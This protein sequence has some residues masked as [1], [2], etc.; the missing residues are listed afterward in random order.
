MD[1]KPNNRFL[2]FLVLWMKKVQEILSRTW[3][4]QRTISWRLTSSRI[5]SITLNQRKRAGKQLSTFRKNLIAFLKKWL[6]RN[7]TR[8][9]DCWDIIQLMPLHH[10]CQ[11]CVH[12]W[13]NY[14]TVTSQTCFVSSGVHFYFLG[15]WW[16]K[17]LAACH[18]GGGC[19]TS[20]HSS[21]RVSPE[22][23]EKIYNEYE[24]MHDAGVIR[25]NWI[26]YSSL[27]ILMKKDSGIGFCVD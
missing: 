2:I 23:Q 18:W 3:Q 7:M 16:L 19:P 9:T 5:L 17:N 8:I 12:L 1:C 25:P 14:L 24:L 11:Q 21:R 4:K 10:I 27:V 13:K 6:H 22:V 15:V 20:A 26:P